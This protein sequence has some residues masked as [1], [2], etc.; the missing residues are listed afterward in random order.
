MSTGDFTNVIRMLQAP[1]YK[2]MYTEGAAFGFYL[3][4][5][6]PWHWEYN[7]PGFQEG[8]WAGEPSLRPTG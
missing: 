6:E 1:A 8:F 4:R 3:Y 2:W 5:N 7:R